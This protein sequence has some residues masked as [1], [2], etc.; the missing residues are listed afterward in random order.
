MLLYRVHSCG[1][2]VQFNHIQYV[3]TKSHQY[4]ITATICNIL[5][6]QSVEPAPW[7]LTVSWSWVQLGQ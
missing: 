3:W 4:G 5:I 7:V 1:T 6:L 2:P